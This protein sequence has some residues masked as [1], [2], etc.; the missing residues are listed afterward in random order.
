MRTDDTAAVLINETG[1]KTLGWEDDPIGKKV[2][3]GFDLN[4]SPGRIMKVVGVLK[5]FHFKSL[6]NKIEPIV[7]FI[8]PEPR[9]LVAARL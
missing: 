5:D 4:G 3:W 8:E 7:V 1:G 2:Q 6:H 9:W